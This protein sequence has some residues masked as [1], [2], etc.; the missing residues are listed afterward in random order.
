MRYAT[1]DVSAADVEYLE[2]LGKKTQGTGRL[3]RRVHATRRRAVC[4]PRPCAQQWNPAD[5]AFSVSRHDF[6]H[7][8]QERQTALRL[9]P[10][11]CSS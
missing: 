4:Q 2:S 5:A 1:G 8:R 7:G 6:R 10:E 3:D 11:R 9:T